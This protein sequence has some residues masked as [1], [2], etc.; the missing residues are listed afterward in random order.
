M[1]ESVVLN[2]TTEARLYRILNLTF[3][4]ISILVYVSLNMIRYYIE[5]FTVLLGNDGIY[6]EL[7]NKWEVL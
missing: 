3:H 7:Y 6:C 1:L 2:F 4:W 5:K